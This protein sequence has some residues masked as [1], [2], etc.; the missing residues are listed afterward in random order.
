MLTIKPTCFTL[1]H[2]SQRLFIRFRT[3]REIERKKKRL[4]EDPN[5]MVHDIYLFLFE[6]K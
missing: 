2:L 4:G 6:T 5:N 3:L 1:L